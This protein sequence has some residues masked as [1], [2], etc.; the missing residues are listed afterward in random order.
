MWRVGE[1]CRFF[2]AAGHL[3][4]SVGA[5]WPSCESSCICSVLMNS[6]DPTQV[7]SCNSTSTPPTGLA[8]SKACPTWAQLQP[9]IGSGQR[10]DL[11]PI[12]THVRAR[13][14]WLLFFFMTRSIRSSWSRKLASNV[15]R[16]ANRNASRSPQTATPFPAD[17]GCPSGRRSVG[18][19][20]ATHMPLAALRHC[21]H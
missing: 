11:A 4:N 8:M 14:T 16:L 9:Q 5:D 13:R 12:S 10:P 1:D 7:P 2:T 3:A 15:S 19:F 18:H 17:W 6:T 21:E 20:H